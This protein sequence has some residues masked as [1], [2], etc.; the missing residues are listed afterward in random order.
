L[1]DR[2][3]LAYSRIQYD[4]IVVLYLPVGKITR[5]CYI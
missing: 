3:S 4:R 2:E 5:V 1:P